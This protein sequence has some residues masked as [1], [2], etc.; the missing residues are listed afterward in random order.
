MFKLKPT[1]LPSHQSSQQLAEDFNDVFSN[2]ISDIRVGHNNTEAAF[3]EAR[4]L[5]CHILDFEIPSHSHIGGWVHHSY[6]T[7]T[8]S[9]DLFQDTIASPEKEKESELR[10][11]SYNSYT[12]PAIRDILLPRSARSVVS[13]GCTVHAL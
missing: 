3:V 10:E 13:S 12:L 5:S 4:E 6:R 1:A 2:K 8:G 11:S 9:K 7:L